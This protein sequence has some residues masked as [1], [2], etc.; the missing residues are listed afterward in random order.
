M[1]EMDGNRRADRV[2][3][4]RPETSA[5]LMNGAPAGNNARLKLSKKAIFPADL[6]QVLGEML[7]A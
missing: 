4:L 6:I 5:L 1:P 3:K 2:L 7:P